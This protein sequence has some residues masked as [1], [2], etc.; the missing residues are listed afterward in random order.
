MIIEFA[1]F[2]AIKKALNLD[3][4]DVK[5]SYSPFCLNAKI[6]D[7][8]SKCKQIVIYGDS[9]EINIFFEERVHSSTINSLSNIGASWSIQTIQMPSENE[10]KVTPIVKNGIMITTT[11]R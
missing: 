10:L 3:D 2:Y 4:K 11:W 7:E 9:H 1:I 5:Y 8:Y 6:N